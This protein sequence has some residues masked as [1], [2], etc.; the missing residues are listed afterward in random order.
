VVPE[1][2]APVRTA[3]RTLR[4][5]FL[6]SKIPGGTRYEPRL[7]GGNIF[8]PANPPELKPGEQYQ[9]T[10]ET[11]VGGTLRIS[12]PAYFRVLD[13]KHMAEVAEL[14]RKLA[15]SPLALA[16]MYESY[17][18]MDDAIAELGKLPGNSNRAG[19]LIGEIERRKKLP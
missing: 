8:D 13:E 4:P 15:G 18:L 1:P 17:G 6:W 10:V 3:V 2:L 12:S 14:S 16:A 7:N 9:W 11:K 19:E 5:V